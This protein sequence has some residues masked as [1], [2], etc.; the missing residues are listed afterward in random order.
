[1]KL[2]SF[3]LDGFV[4]SAI[5]SLGFAA[6]AVACSAQSGDPAETSSQAIH[7]DTYYTCAPTGACAVTV[8]LV[9]AGDGWTGESAC[10][11][12]SGCTWT[13]TADDA[14][15]AQTTPCASGDLATA[16]ECTVNPV[17]KATSHVVVFG[18]GPH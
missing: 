16:E 1:M 5:A 10:A 17:C 15:C 18:G 9:D 6:F 4:R 12:V 7:V 3:A 2:A 14:Y 11:T 8:A 13:V